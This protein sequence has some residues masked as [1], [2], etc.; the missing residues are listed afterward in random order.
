MKLFVLALVL[1][2]VAL[3]V[4]PYDGLRITWNL[5]PFSNGF[6]AMP[7]DLNNDDLDGFVEIDN[8]CTVNGQFRGVRYWKDND[9]AAILLFDVNGYIAGIQTS[10]LQSEYTPPTPS[11][12]HPYLADGDYW[13]LTIYFV[14]PSTICTTGRTADEYAAQG[15]G[16]GFWMQNGTDPDTQ[17][18][19]APQNEADVA[20]N[21]KWVLG[22][23]FWTMGNH[24]WYDVSSDMDCNQMFPFFL[25]YNKGRVN[26][27]GFAMNNAAESSRYEH[28]PQAVI[29]QFMDPVPKCFGTGDFKSQ[30]T[31][32]VYMTDYPRTGCE[33]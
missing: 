30:T 17:S 3:A 7:R 29:G 21:T 20:A 19:Q 2:A 16:T 28:P 26:A 13:T 25:L 32:H 11:I 33:C 22:H 24:Y 14:D 12:G 1:P 23:C 4:D 5:N 8:Q 9:P 6:D 15:T 27:G 18:L 10:V 31:M